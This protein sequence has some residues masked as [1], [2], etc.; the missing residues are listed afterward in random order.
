VVDAF[1]VEADGSLTPI[2]PTSG[3]PTGGQGLAAR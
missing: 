2:G 3:N 1:R